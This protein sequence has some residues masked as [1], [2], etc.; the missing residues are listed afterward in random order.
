MWIELRSYRNKYSF[1]LIDWKIKTLA[2]DIIVSNLE[3]R[4]L[5]HLLIVA[6][7]LYKHCVLFLFIVYDL[8]TSFLPFTVFSVL[9]KLLECWG[10]RELC[11]CIFAD[12]E[13]ELPTLATSGNRI[14]R[15]I[16]SSRVARTEIFLS[17][18]NEKQLYMSYLRSFIIQL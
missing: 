18:P 17:K 16:S 3:L 13:L 4:K 12:T 11:S 8:Y 2:T 9:E 10:R 1:N 5:Q 15:S 6:L 14:P 7:S